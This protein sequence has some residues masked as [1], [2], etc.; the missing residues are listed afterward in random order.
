M[1]IYKAFADPF[2]VS[3][4]T[5]SQYGATN[6]ASLTNGGLVAVTGPTEDTRITA[7]VFNE[8]GTVVR[9]EIALSV[10]A[11][12]YETAA[13]T[14]L[15]GGGFVVTWSVAT[16]SSQG[17][18]VRDVQ[19][20]IFT[21]AGQAVSGEFLVNASSTGNQTLSAITSLSNGGFVVSWYD[22]TYDEGGPTPVL[23]ARIFSATGEV[24]KD[25]F[26]VSAQ[27]IEASIAGLANGGFAV[28][29][30]EQGSGTFGDIKSK[31]FNSAGAVVKA[32]FLV[33][34]NTADFQYRPNV[35]ALTDGS[36]VVSWIDDGW[37]DQGSGSKIKAKVF[38]PPAR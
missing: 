5:G 21:A 25:E 37:S 7:T 14:G 26:L 35:T 30:S 27:G 34:T 13:V 9:S 11:S 12:P 38:T 28:T 4:Q 6:I 2:R 18:D 8:N 15:S 16:G 22:G 23:K 36:F 24:V 32:E 3:M 31:I 33:N 20:K 1:A 29:W 17:Q 19:A 10:E